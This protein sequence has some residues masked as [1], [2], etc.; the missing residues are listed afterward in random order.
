MNWFKKS[1]KKAVKVIDIGEHIRDFLYDTQLEEAEELA[2]ILGATPISKEGQDHA[3]SLSD[4]RMTKLANL[5]PVVHAYAHMVSEAMVDFE[6]QDA[7]AEGELEPANELWGMMH[8]LIE[9]STTAVALGV[10]SQA[11]ELGLIK[12][13]EK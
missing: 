9:T 13:T 12:V 3:R 6:R 11:Q 8:I 1:K 7:E 10:L 4:A 2:L 5:I